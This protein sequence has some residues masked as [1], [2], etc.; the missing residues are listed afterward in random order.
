MRDR[1][2]YLLDFGSLPEAV[3]KEGDWFQGR[4]P[5]G[6]K[7]ADTFRILKIEYFERLARLLSSDPVRDHSSITS[8]SMG[9]LGHADAGGMAGV[10]QC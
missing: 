9:G 6:L 1:D 2:D 5:N 7:N 10:S 3:F 4:G 8:A